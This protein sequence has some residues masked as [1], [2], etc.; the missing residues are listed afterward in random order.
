MAAGT[1]DHSIDLVSLVRQVISTVAALAAL[2]AIRNLTLPVA[3]YCVRTSVPLYAPLVVGLVLEPVRSLL[4]NVCRRNVRRGA[5]VGYA[6]EALDASH[7]RASSGATHAAFIAERAVSVDVPGFIA[8]VVA[9]VV[10]LALSVTRLGAGLVTGVLFVLGCAILLGAWWQRER[11]PLHQAVVQTVGKLG[12]WMTVATVDQ[13]EVSADAARRQ[14]LRQVGR[15]SDNWSDAEAKLARS[16]LLVRAGLGFVVLIGCMV[17]FVHGN[18]PWLMR[19]LATIRDRNLVTVA[20]F[21]VLASVLPALVSAARHWDALLGSRSELSVLRPLVRPKP[22]LVQQMRQRPSRLEVTNLEIRY[23]SE[24]GVRVAELSVDISRPLILVGANG[25]GKSTLLGA[26]AGALEAASGT[27]LIDGVASESLDREQVAFV[28]QE[29]VLIESLTLLENSQLVA[30]K[31]TGMELA[32]YLEALGLKCNVHDPLGSLSRGERR[33]VAIARAL[34]KYPRLLLLDEPDA[35][36]D[37]HGRQLLLDALKA[38]MM[39]TAIV[40]VTH[41]L[42][43]A[44]FGATVAVLGPDQSLEAVGQIEQLQQHSATFQAVVGG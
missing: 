40:I 17:V 32:A 11:R 1:Q 12:A 10:L 34:L 44:R 27:V 19:E 14:Y 21:I 42:E 26:I 43:L 24:L 33:R 2:L 4:S 25:C 35:W 15:A 22:T 36:L 18:V 23:E 6:Y 41:R 28:P 7:L 8:A 39:D 37:A 38:I 5:M 31:A 9:T 20:D 3:A 13:G 16:R 29:P 30:P